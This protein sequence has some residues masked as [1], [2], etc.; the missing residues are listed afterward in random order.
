MALAKLL[1]VTALAVAAAWP[2]RLDDAQLATPFGPIAGV[3]EDGIERFVGVRYAAPP[4]G[5]RRFRR[6]A[7]SAPGAPSPT[8]ARPTARRAT[9][10][11]A[12][13][14]RPRPTPPCT[15]RSR[16]ADEDCLFVAYRPARPSPAGKR[17]V[18]V[19]VHGGGFCSGAG[20]T[21]WSE[22]S[23]L[24]DR[25]DAILLTLNYRLGPLGFASDGAEGGALGLWDV[26]TAL[27]FARAALIEPLGGDVDAS[28]PCV[29]DAPKGWGPGDPALGVAA[30]RRVLGLLGVASLDEAR[31]LD[32]S[33]LQWAPVDMADPNFPGWWLDATL[34]PGLK[35]P[36]AYYLADPPKTH[37]RDFIVGTTSKDGTAAFY[38][39]APL[40][41]VTGSDVYLRHLE[42]AWGSAVAARVAEH[43]SLDNFGGDV[44]AAFIQADADHFLH[45]PSLAMARSLNREADRAA[46][47][48]RGGAGGPGGPR[49]RAP[50]TRGGA[51]RGAGGDARLP[52]ERPRDTPLDAPLPFACHGADV[53]FT[54]G[55]EA[56]PDGLSS[57]S[58]TPRHDC[59]YSQ[60][61]RRLG[62]GPRLLGSF[63]RGGRPV[64]EGDADGG[65]RPGGG[66]RKLASDDDGGIATV[67]RFR[68]A[69]CAFWASVDDEVAAALAVNWRQ[70][71]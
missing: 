54:F 50:G 14:A 5:D 47:A 44:A 37:V 7:V 55:N 23:R 52:A 16:A 38:G 40:D 56:G 24:A 48:G 66:V 61:G 34:F 32:A 68:A 43:Y 62:R 27:E 60:S 36:S 4:T 58:P 71:A 25:E 28:G 33:S 29:V 9:R 11:P 15:G 6:A 69:D 41:N 39:R 67:D 53:Q 18:M 65:W 59:P 8:T 63:A 31:S 3:V 57:D 19:W 17:P 30:T 20:A 35:P 1:R 21:G 51:R 2:T 46:A 64:R 49:P 70:R 42:R 13:S 26:I 10:A 45:C 12:A 22:G